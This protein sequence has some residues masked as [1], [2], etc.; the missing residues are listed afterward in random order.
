M[1]FKIDY[2]IK[3]KMQAV[4]TS[5]IT[6]DGDIGV[7]FDRFVYE[8][9][10]GGFAIK[11]ILGEAEKCFA[12]KYDDEYGEGMWRGEFWGKLV[13]SAAR[14]ARMKNDE[15]LKCELAKSVKRMLAHQCE[16]GY[17]STYRDRRNLFGGHRDDPTYPLVGWDSNWN[18]WG[19][20]YT[21]WALIECAMLLDDSSILEAAKKVAD[22]AIAAI[23]SYDMC[24]T[25]S[26][27][28]FGMAAGSLMKPMLIL[29]RLTGDKKYYD[30]SVTIAADWER[31]DGKW[32]NLITNS[33]NETPV[34][35]WYDEADGWAAKAY[36]M[37]SCFEGICEL[38]RLT[39]DEHLLLATERFWTLVKQGE[40]NILGSVGYCERFTNAKA[41]P[42]SATEI[43]DAI[44]WMR[45]SYEL[46]TITG[47][48]QYAEAFERAFLN[49]FLAGVY[50][51]GRGGAF[52]VRSSGRHWVSGVQCDT[53]YQ[54]CCLN[55]VPR[56]FV[57]AAEMAVTKS[58]G[59]YYINAYYQTTVR[60]GDV[61]FRISDG[62]TDKGFV[63]ITVRGL[64]PGTV[65]YMRAPEW[66]AKTSALPMASGQSVE[67]TRGEYTPVAVYSEYNT[68]IKV[69][70]DMTPKVIPFGGEFKEL[71]MT[72]YHV[73]RWIDPRAGV[74]DRS[75]MLKGPM[76][77]VQV[78][79]VVL[80]RSKRIGSAEADMFSG[81]TV[82]GK[83][84]QCTARPIR[85]NNLLALCRVSIKADG[86]TTEYLM[87]DYAS[88]ANCDTF[89]PKYFTVFI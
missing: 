60:D 23:E 62:Y 76:C 2:K 80:A 70:F 63:T 7:R 82:F 46:L 29:Y 51:D 66:S 42:D 15:E 25:G 12:D 54:H 22:S 72:D 73:H 21:L 20:K 33:L 88:A 45:L 77:T 31:E 79:P 49:A 24:P 19:Q 78:G 34:H 67:M 41:F 36:E 16:D 14:V 87:C 39:G 48:A 86:E 30:F 5:S 4:P 3:N 27:V 47:K 65:I 37:M 1:E 28:Q 57:N 68:I 6:L 55:N 74:C 56:G 50:D 13:I 61:S 11:E 35:L 89:D 53:K 40:S 18:T 58:D 17:L 43:C 32:P 83:E 81:K 8:R 38:Y 44:H 71:P 84:V 10:S 64:K 85:R 69:S 52:F 9:V 75:S 59:A 26:G